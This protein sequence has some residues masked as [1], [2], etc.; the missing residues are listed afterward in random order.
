MSPKGKGVSAMESLYQGMDP[1]EALDQADEETNR[2]L[3]VANK[4]QGN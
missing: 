1:K 3:E 2:A 4:K